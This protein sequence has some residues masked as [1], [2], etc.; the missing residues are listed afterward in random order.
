M[1]LN[2]WVAESSWWWI[3]IACESDKFIVKGNW[4]VILGAEEFNRENVYKKSVI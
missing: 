2:L 4:T 3:V 1:K